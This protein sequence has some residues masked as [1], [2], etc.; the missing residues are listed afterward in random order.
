VPRLAT[1][2]YGSTLVL[3]EKVTELPAP[4]AA[5]ESLR[6]SRRE[7]EATFEILD[8]LVEAAPQRV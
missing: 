3:T 5:L 4:A 2:D 8:D 6:V 7:A 1:G